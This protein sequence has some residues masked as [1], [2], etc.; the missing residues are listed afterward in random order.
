MTKYIKSQRGGL[1]N[2]ANTFSF[3][4]EA[5]PVDYGRYMVRAYGHGI[6]YGNEDTYHTASVLF[7]GIKDACDKIMAEIENFLFNDGH[8]LDLSD[9]HFV[10]QDEAITKSHEEDDDIKF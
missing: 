5:D 7:E 3:D 10:K 9:P 1:V 8:L 2:V 4:I 6:T